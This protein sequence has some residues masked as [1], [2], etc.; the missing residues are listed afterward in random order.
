MPETSAG[1]CAVSRERVCIGI[2][3]GAQGIRGAVRIKSF[4]AAP[5]NVAAYGP[6]EDEAGARQFDL[7]VVGMARGAVVAMVAGVADR[8]AA[9]RLTGMKLFVKRA[10]LPP[11]EEE[12]YYHADLLGL[13]VVLADGTKVG[14]VRAIHDFGAGD[15]IEIAREEGGVVMAPFTRSVVPVV[16]LAGG[17]LVLDPPPGLLEPGEPEGAREAE[18]EG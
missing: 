6:V 1:P 7:R 17:R 14:R 13:E 5:E 9:E 15:S 10:A 8:N 12:E 16:D 18:T 3:V 11:P 4:T 2:V